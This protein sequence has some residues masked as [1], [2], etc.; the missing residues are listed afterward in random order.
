[1][2]VSTAFQKLPADNGCYNGQLIMGG[3]VSQIAAASAQ[4]SNAKFLGEAHYQVSHSLYGNHGYSSLVGGTTGLNPLASY[5][6]RLYHFL[7]Q[8]TPLSERLAISLLY[9]AQTVSGTPSIIIR[10]RPTTGSSYSATAID[11]GIKF[12]NGT[13]IDASLIA[14]G[15]IARSLFTGC[16]LIDAPT[17]T[18]PESPRPLYVPTSNRGQLL[19]I[20]IE[21]NDVAL[22]AVHIYDIFVPEVTP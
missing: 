20:E 18:N 17:N 19:N 15:T 16:E 10:L 21:V 7:Y 12:D 3:T 11:N 1:M 5:K 8:S 9:A 13:H 22:G 4:L 2:L 6:S 14:D